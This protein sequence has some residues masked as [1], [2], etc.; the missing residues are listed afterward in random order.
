MTAI[1]FDSF[2][3]A[4]KLMHDAEAKANAT[5]T[6]RQREIV[7]G[8]Y[9]IRAQGTLLE[10]GRV[11]SQEEVEGGEP[12]EMVEVLR[13]TYDRGYRFSWTSSILGQT[14]ADTHLAVMWP[15]TE[16]E[17]NLAKGNNW[18]PSDEDWWRD[19]LVRIVGEI[20]EANDAAHP[21]DP[22]SPQEETP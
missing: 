7:Y 8:S 14:L 16:E 17:Y 12:P 22:G 19:M 1:P 18:E 20:A 4:A 11:L 21:S 2:D 13:Q 15:I 6:D 3:E 5:V 9:W 10:Y